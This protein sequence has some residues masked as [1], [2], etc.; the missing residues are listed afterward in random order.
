MVQEACIFRIFSSLSWAMIHDLEVRVKHPEKVHR[1]FGPTWEN[2]GH[3]DDIGTFSL[4]EG[5]LPG[6]HVRSFL[7]VPPMAEYGIRACIFSVF[8]G[9]VT[10]IQ[11][12][13]GQTKRWP[14][15]KLLVAF[16]TLRIYLLTY[17]SLKKSCR[18]WL[19]GRVVFE[20]R[21]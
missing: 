3:L 10:F 8:L 6:F 14:F 20:A 19:V 5:C 18:V 7:F 13:M 21:F 15:T 4:E 2:T 16:Q 9:F 1:S 12:G 11:L 17:I